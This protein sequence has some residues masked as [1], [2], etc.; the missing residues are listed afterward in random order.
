M[1]SLAFLFALASTLL[2]ASASGRADNRAEAREHFSQGTKLF[3]LGRFADAA[4]EYAEAYKLHDEPLLLYNVAQAQRLAGQTADALRSYKTFLRL[5]PK[6]QNRIEVQNKIAELE[7]LVAQ[8]EKTQ[9]LRPDYPITPSGMKGT[10]KATRPEPEVAR[11]E[12]KPEPKPEPKAKPEPKP[13]PVAADPTPE[14]PPVVV[15]EPD[16]APKVAK[17]SESKPAPGRVKIIAGAAILVVGVGVIGGGVAM[18]LA[19]K[20]AGD[21]VTKAASAGQPFDPKKESSGKQAQLIGGVLYG[22]GGACVAAGAVVLAL[23][24]IEGKKAASAHARLV[25]VMAP[26]YAG[27][28]LQGTF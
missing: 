17:Q 10:D 22:V 21:D 12:P 16:P 20:A 26:G 4:V 27:A 23:G 15:A 25:P 3:N 6:A 18:G 2:V 7:K 9:K 24:A 5:V 14:R 28:L 1:R 19:A 11:V 8:T 13:E